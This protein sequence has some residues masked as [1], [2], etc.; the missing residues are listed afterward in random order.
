MKNNKA[1]TFIETLVAMSILMM[2]VVTI[3]PI[4]TLMKQERK[5][6][7]DRRLIVSKL[8]DEL[9]HMVWSNE[10]LQHVSITINQRHVNIEFQLENELI[11]GCATWENVKQKEETFCL[12]GKREARWIHDD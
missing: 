2:L 1:F 9:Q 11:K 7:R 4:H 8:H 5:V 12:F 6:L 3:I 10:E